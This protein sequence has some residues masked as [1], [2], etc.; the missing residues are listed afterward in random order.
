MPAIL[1][2]MAKQKKPATTTVRVETSLQEDLE[3]IAE[4]LDETTQNDVTIATLLGEWSKPHVAKYRQ[5]AIDYRIEK[6]KKMRENN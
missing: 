4:Y 3:L 2:R 5:K 1:D 6:L